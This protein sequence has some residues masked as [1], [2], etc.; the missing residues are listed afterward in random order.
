MTKIIESDVQ[1]F[2]DKRPSAD[3]HLPQW[4]IMIDNGSDIH[5]QMKNIQMHLICTEKRTKEM[6][7]IQMFVAVSIVLM[8][9]AAF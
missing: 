7:S 8:Y 3:L 6:L 1:G 2:F 5:G 9:G 4:F